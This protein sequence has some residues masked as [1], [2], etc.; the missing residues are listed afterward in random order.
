MLRTLDDNVN[1]LFQL[2]DGEADVL[3]DWAENR[4]PLAASGSPIAPLD[5]SGLPV[6]GRQGQ[7]DRAGVLADYLRIFVGKWNEDLSPDGELSWRAV[8]DRTGSYLGLLFET[9]ERNEAGSQSTENDGE[10]QGDLRAAL[11]NLSRT[12]D[13]DETH[14]IVNRGIVRIV[15]DTYMA[16]I[17]PSEKR[18]W[19]KSAAREDYE[20]TLVQAM[21]LAPTG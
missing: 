10:A 16:I 21:N 2:S 13:V 3:Q 4:L 8:A 7:I 12:L 11:T 17:K 9:E 20:A 19:S 1:M 15:G 5:V 6:S 18:L 14:N